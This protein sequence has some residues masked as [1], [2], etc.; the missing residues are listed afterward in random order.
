MTAK[1]APGF[2]RFGSS[3]FKFHPE[4]VSWEHAFTICA[5]ENATL[6]S[7]RNQK[8]EKFL[9]TLQEKG[10]GKGWMWIGKKRVMNTGIVM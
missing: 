7:V 5:N 9:R 8:E 1:C 10:K 4:K 6:T 3:C 2:T